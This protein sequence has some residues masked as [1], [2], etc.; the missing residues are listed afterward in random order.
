MGQNAVMNTLEQFRK[1]LEALDIQVDKLILFGSHAI[2]KAHEESDIDTIVI[3]SSFVDKGYW[4]RIDIL[5]QAIYTVFA[6]IDA[7]AF[8]PDEWESNRSLLTDYAKDGI[9]I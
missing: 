6:P 2:G 3:S 9:T 4:E 8:T 1:A 7:V 5:S